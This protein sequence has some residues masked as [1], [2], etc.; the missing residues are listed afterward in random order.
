MA[1]GDLWLPYWKAQ[2]WLKGQ[3]HLH[4]ESQRHEGPCAQPFHGR[5]P[6]GYGPSP[7]HPFPLTPHLPSARAS[8][9]MGRFIWFREGAP[10]SRDTMRGTGEAGGLPPW[11]TG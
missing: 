5:E 10:T 3:W 7:P 9:L 6:T 2:L 4:K 1:A 8:K 11:D